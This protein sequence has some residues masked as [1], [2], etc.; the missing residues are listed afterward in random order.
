M[1][2]RMRTFKQNYERSETQFSRSGR[3]VDDVELGCPQDAGECRGDRSRQNRCYIT[4]SYLHDVQ[5]QTTH[6][7][8]RRHNGLRNVPDRMN[9]TEGI[10]DVSGSGVR[11]VVEPEGDA[12]SLDHDEGHF[13]LPTFLIL[14][15]QPSVFLIRY[16]GSWKTIQRKPFE[17]ERMSTD[18]AWIQILENVDAPTAYRLW[19]E[20]QRK[21]SRLL[22]Q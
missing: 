20:R 10:I 8:R 7:T 22:Q 15:E 1:E 19:F 6:W 13:H 11:H 5:H 17:P 9:H 4:L 21:L 18:V 2:T 12:R 16:N 14:M 3:R